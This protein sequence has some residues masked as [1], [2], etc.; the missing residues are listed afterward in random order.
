M[1]DM[2]LPPDPS[3]ESDDEDRRTSGLLAVVV[4][5]VLLIGGLV[6]TKTLYQ[7]NKISECLMSG[8]HDCELL[9]R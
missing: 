8:R 4:V 9:T 6:L 5:L 7:K 2:R 1:P 3:S